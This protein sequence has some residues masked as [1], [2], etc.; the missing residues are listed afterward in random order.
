MR[1]LC[2]LVLIVFAMGCKDEK[3]EKDD[4]DKL[5]LLK[6]SK[7]T[8]G[9]IWSSSTVIEARFTLLDTSAFCVCDLTIDECD[10]DCD[11]DNMCA[12]STPDSEIGGSLNCDS[13]QFS[14]TGGNQCIPVAWKCDGIPNCNDGSDEIIETC[15]DA[16]NNSGALEIVAESSNS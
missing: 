12:E 11:C 7:H 10:S 14:C 8:D 2:V 3:K 4:E 1:L 15:P 9:F 13:D 16:G 6:V 5:T